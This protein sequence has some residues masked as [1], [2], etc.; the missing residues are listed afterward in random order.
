MIKKRAI[1]KSLFWCVLLGLCFTLS[2]CFVASSSDNPY[3][4]VPTTNNPHVVP[5]RPIPGGMAY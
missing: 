2:G 5:S 4:T 1:Q 3:N